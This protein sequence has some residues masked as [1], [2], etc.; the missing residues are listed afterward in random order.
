MTEDNDLVRTSDVCEDRKRDE[1]K[2]SREEERGRNRE[3]GIEMKIEVETDSGGRRDED[4]GVEI[5]LRWWVGGERVKRTRE[6]K[7]CT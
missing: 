4:R 3:E 1:R 7:M 6:G 2:R 5:D